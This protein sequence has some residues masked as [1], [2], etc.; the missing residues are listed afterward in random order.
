M[1][2]DDE[3]FDEMEDILIFDED[4]EKVWGGIFDVVEPQRIAEDFNMPVFVKS[5]GKIYKND[6]NVWHYW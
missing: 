6:N 5:T 2:E 4:V 1:F 3:E